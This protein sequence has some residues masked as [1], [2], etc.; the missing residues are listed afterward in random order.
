V[1]V[2]G[3]NVISLRDHL[4]FALASGGKA[5][6]E[7]HSELDPNDDQII[8]E[9]LSTLNDAIKNAEAFEPDEVEEFLGATDYLMTTTLDF[10]E[11]TANIDTGDWQSLVILIPY[12][13]IPLVLVIGVVLA[14]LGIHIHTLEWVLTWIIHPLFILQVIFASI[15][16]SII[17]MFA[18]ANADFCSGGEDNTPDSSVKDILVNMGWKRWDFEYTIIEFYIGQCSSRTP[19][20]FLNEYIGDVESMTARVIEFSGAVATAAD[21]LASV[22][23]ND[24]CVSDL[25]FIQALNTVM[26]ANLRDV[27]GRLQ[28]DL[29]D[30]LE[31]KNIVDI[32]TVPIY[33]GTCTYSINGVSWAWA[34]FFVVGLMGMVMIMLRSSWVVDADE[35]VYAEGKSVV[36]GDS[37]EE[38]ES[39]GNPYN[40]GR[41]GDKMFEDTFYEEGLD[42]Y[43]SENEM[44]GIRYNMF[45]D[46]TVYEEDLGGMSDP[47]EEMSDDEGYVPKNEKTGI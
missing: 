15:T 32:Y 29:G 25:S 21:T 30:I 46:T 3:N 38:K 24:A 35:D 17:L 23:P 44:T 45:E 37:T 16:C 22:A 6:L 41:D 11:G 20:G 18:S 36:S 40:P 9:I 8:L 34:S 47:G 28:D 27:I 39:I 2:I 14:Y 19:F 43:L 7:R 10:E 33:Q 13:I 4:V 12:T 42:G 1:Q 31:C 5:C 26:L